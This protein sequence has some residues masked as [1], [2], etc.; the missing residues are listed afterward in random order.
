MIQPLLS[1][2]WNRD[3]LITTVYPCIAIPG[4]ADLGG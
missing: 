2:D 4:G 1:M 3:E